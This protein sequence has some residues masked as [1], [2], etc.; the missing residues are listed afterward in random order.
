MKVLV[1]DKKT[2][3][4]KL[5]VETASDL[6]RLSRLV[7]KGDSVGGFTH[8]RD[9]EAP[10]D[11]PEA[12]RERRPVF[13]SLRVEKI[14][15]HEFTGHLRFTGPITEAPFDIGRHH[16]L[17]FEQG[18][19]VSLLKPELNASDWALIDE[20]KRS[21]GEPRLVIACID[22]SEGT[23][24]RVHGRTNEVIQEF[25]RTGT[26][27]YVHAPGGKKEKEN[28]QYLVD[29]VTTLEREV[30]GAKALIFS[31]PGFCKE[32]LFRHWKSAPR[33][34]PVPLVEA[35]AEAGMPGIQELLRSG[36]AESALSGSLSAEEAREVERLVRSLGTAGLAAVGPKE[37]TKA[38]DA[39]AVERLL[40]LDTHLR[41]PS[42]AESL[43][44]VRSGG[45]KILIVRHEGEAGKRLKG[46][47]GIAAI[48]RYPLA[49]S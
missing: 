41:E 10:A 31:G 14:E 36:K 3:F 28:E 15:F 29:I 30:E 47:G 23:L 20:G 33:K 39:G 40:V 26:G 21:L 7:V 35:T 19:D 46:L 44:A 42:V 5:R 32:S 17:D 27:K 11:T 48:L 18:A 6:W 24:V 8:R 12:Q 34:G 25:N 4:L 37:V 1:Y 43:D 38:S 16:T 13:L 9:P 2:H 49:L 22:W 45:G